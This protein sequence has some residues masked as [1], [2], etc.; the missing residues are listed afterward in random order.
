MPQTTTA[1]NGCDIAISL[2][3]ADGNLTDISG[4][5]N[6]VQIRITNEIRTFRRVNA[7]FPTRKLTGKDATADIIILYSTGADE[8][9][10]IIRDWVS[11]AIDG[12][13]ARTL[14]VD[15]PDSSI[16]SDRY[17]ME[18]LPTGYDLSLAAD[19]AAPATIGIS[20][21]STG[22]LEVTQIS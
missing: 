14:R 21:S 3:D 9:L 11:A 15:I 12:D 4:S 17:Q 19:E 2:D 16:G 20:F 6:A 22:G 13:D 8:A 1:V 10:D 7:D 5:T 18:A